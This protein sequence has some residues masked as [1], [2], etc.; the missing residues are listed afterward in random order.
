MADGDVH[1]LPAVVSDERMHD[2][3]RTCWCDPIVRDNVVE[4]IDIEN[5]DS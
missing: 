2:L 3:S 4:H 5:G 1:D